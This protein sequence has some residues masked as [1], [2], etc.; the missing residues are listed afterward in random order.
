[1]CVNESGIKGRQL[2]NG[3]GDASGPGALPKREECRYLQRGANDRRK[4]RNDSTAIFKDRLS[5]EEPGI[6]ARKR[7][8]APRYAHQPDGSIGPRRAIICAR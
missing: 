2:R 3:C 1:M 5:A 6:I 7:H 4:G 8:D